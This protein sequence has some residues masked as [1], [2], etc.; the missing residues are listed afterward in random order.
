MHNQYCHAYLARC[1]SWK[2]HRGE[3]IR[4]HKLFHT[5]GSGDRWCTRTK[6]LIR[7][8]KL[9]HT[10]ESGDWQCTI[11]KFLI[12]F[13]KLFHTGKSGDR[14]GRGSSGE[15]PTGAMRAVTPSREGGSSEGSA[16]AVMATIL[17]REGQPTRMER[18]DVGR[19][20]ESKRRCRFEKC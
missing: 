20:R 18:G 12:R 3:S 4:F 11:T 2:C 7:F 13:H 5:G 15:G 10:G 9:F 17:T 19:H 16:C 8:H 14:R 6:L 1:H